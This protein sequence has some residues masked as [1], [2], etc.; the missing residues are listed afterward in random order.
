MLSCVCRFSTPW[1]VARQAP[2]SIECSRQEY[3]SGLPFPSPGDLPHPGIK[4]WSPALHCRQIL[5]HLSHQQ[6]LKHTSFPECRG[7]SQLMATVS[8]GNKRQVS[9]TLALEKTS[10]GSVWPHS[11]SLGQVTK[12]CLFHLT[13]SLSLIPAF[14]KRAVM[15]MKLGIFFFSNCSEIQRLLLFV[16]QSPH[17]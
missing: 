15:L 12:R 13:P 3:Q 4:P 1:T 9:P 11:F 5:Y 17:C 16:N 10:T 2:L 7:G 14:D 8:S 6:S